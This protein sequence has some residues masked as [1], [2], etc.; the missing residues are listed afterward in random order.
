MLLSENNKD[1]LLLRKVK[2]ESPKARL[3]I[4]I[5]TTKIM[6]AEELHRLDVDDEEIKIP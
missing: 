1:L 2:E 5:K 3:Q 6:T 4:N